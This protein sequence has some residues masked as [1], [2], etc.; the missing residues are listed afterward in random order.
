MKTAETNIILL[1]LGNQTTLYYLE[2]LNELYHKELG[3]FHTFPCVIYNIDFNDINPYLPN[4]FD[5]LTPRLQDYLNYLSDNFIGQLLIPN[6]TLHE[7]YDKCQSELKIIH[8]L[9][10]AKEYIQNNKIFQMKIFGSKYTM[11]SDYISSNLKSLGIEITTPDN[12]D[13]AFLDT[14][15]KNV[16]EDKNTNEDLIMYQKLLDKYTSNCHVLI[17]CTELSIINSQCAN[18]KTIDLATLQMKSAIHSALNSN[19]N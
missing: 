14:I 6:I 1:G 9:Q 11:E 16:Y 10:L 13:K 12:H 2:T 7:T 4:Q 5:E 19:K 8:P 17:A 15:R 3:G 18:K